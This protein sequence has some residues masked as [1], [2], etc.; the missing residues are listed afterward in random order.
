MTGGAGFVG[1][2]LVQHLME[3]NPDCKIAI[4]D[5]LSNT[6][7][8]FD[9]RN[10]HILF[11]NE[12]IRNHET[13]SDIVKRERIDTCIHLA[14]IV[15]VAD[16][17]LYP[18]ETI[19]IN[20]KGTL[21]VFEACA[22]ND[23]KNIV[24]ASSASVYGNPRILP[25]PEEHILEPL[26]PYGSSKASGEALLSSYKNCGKI[27]NAVSLRFF[28]IYGKGQNPEYAGVITK[29]AHQ[30]SKGLPPIIYGTGEQT[31]DFI[32]VDDVVRAIMKA[33]KANVSG[34]FNIGTGR[35]L[36]M[37]ELAMR[38]IKA[39]NLDILPIYKEA[40]RGDIIHSYAN[41]AKSNNVLKFVANTVIQSNLNYH[42]I[43]SIL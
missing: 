26:S 25:I 5:T 10:K 21:S 28:N 23:V 11:Y 33:A 27:K 2:H 31:R 20:I 22:K 3:S 42:T 41:T 6:G 30:L 4:V 16:S 38:M 7:K 24:F 43:A 19:D 13:L 1:R 12:D 17:I 32:S 18:F 37:N 9:P 35:P 34:I 14:A 39:F 15:S 36:S 29:F 8:G 40:Q